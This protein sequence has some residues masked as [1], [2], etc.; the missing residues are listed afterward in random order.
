MCVVLCHQVYGN[1]LQQHWETNAVMKD[2]EELSRKESGEARHFFENKHKGYGRTWCLEGTVNS[3]MCQ[4]TWWWTLGVTF[5]ASVPPNSLLTRWKFC[6]GPPSYPLKGRC[7]R[8]SWHHSPL[9]VGRDWLAWG[10]CQPLTSGWLGSEHEPSRATGRDRKIHQGRG[11]WGTLPL[12]SL[13]TLLGLAV[14]PG[15]EVERT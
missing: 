4:K 2:V 6:S 14:M 10:W 9:G 13:C 15:R 12:L 3:S 8:G 5:P 1:L 11:L 7:L